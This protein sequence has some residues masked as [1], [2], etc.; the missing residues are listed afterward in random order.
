MTLLSLVANAERAPKDGPQQEILEDP[1]F[2]Y[3][4]SCP[5]VPTTPHILAKSSLRA[6]E[7]HAKPWQG[8][9]Q[10]S[11]LLVNEAFNA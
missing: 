4:L 9:D 6:F 8:V 11:A 2:H 1:F 10:F 5:A 7:A 3:H